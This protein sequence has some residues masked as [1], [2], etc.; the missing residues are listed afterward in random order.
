MRAIRTEIDIEAP[1]ER[2]WQILTDLIFGVAEVPDF[3]GP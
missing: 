3:C 1:A 2:V